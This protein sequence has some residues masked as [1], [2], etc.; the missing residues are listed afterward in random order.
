[1]MSDLQQLISLPSRD[2][3]YQFGQPTVYLKPLELARLTLLRSR[4]G[5]TSTE[6]AAENI[7]G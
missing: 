6:R 1:M 2:D 3:E 7:S 4:L 5:E